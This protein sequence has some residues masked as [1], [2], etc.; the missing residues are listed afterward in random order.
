MHDGGTE[1]KVRDAWFKIKWAVCK[2]GDV[3]DFRAKVRGHTSSIEI[4]LLTILV[5]T[6]NAERRQ[7]QLR[8]TSLAN[9]IQILY[10]Q[11]MAV[12]GFLARSLEVSVQQGKVLGATNMIIGTVSNVS[13]EEKII[14]G[15]NAYTKVNTG[16][17]T[18][19][20]ASVSFSLQLSDVESGRVVS[21]KT[22]NNKDAG[23]GFLGGLIAA[24]TNGAIAGSREDAI[25]GAIKAS[26][27]LILTWI[28]ES[29]PPEIKIVS[30]EERDSHGFPKTILVSG[31]DGTLQKGSQL[32]I[33][34]IAMVDMGAGKP[35]LR[36]ER[37]LVDL[38]VTEI[39]GDIT[40]CKVTSG[41][42]VIEERMK[43]GATLHCK[44]R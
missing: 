7:Q 23:G 27:K 26:K 14:S 42:K 1:S 9:M 5:E 28:N 21:S 11:A 12:L 38:K 33:N 36:R 19:Y 22:F 15:Y 24:S 39:Q 4:L 35:P 29:F 40:V 2:K 10:F 16:N 41:E 31:I 18:Q 20:S 17:T 8:H 6:A 25:S 43:S 13:V 30:I 44:I 34:E 32:A 3:E 37:K